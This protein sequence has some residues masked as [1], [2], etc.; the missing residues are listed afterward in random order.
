MKNN[1]T[2]TLANLGTS[3]A[4]KKW[5]AHWNRGCVPLESLLFKINQSSVKLAVDKYLV[6]LFDF[7]SF[8]WHES[9]YRLVSAAAARLHSYEG[10]IH[11]GF[12]LNTWT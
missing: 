8:V 4:G 9:P 11:A 6:G 10:R 2:H 5:Q 3:F 12:Q 1:V 7:T